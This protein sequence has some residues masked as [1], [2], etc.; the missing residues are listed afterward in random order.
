M[1]KLSYY[2]FIYLMFIYILLQLKER[3]KY[4]TDVVHLQM[5]LT[6]EQKCKNWEKIKNQRQDGLTLSRAK[7]F[8]GR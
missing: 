7:I 1:F 3:A 6:P 5:N 2:M 8:D 4:T